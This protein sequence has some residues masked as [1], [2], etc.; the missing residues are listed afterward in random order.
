MEDSTSICIDQGARTTDTYGVVED[1][2]IKCFIGSAEANFP[3][4]RRSINV[5]AARL[6]DTLW[7]SAAEL[8]GR[9]LPRNRRAL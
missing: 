4:P 1:C 7:R 3:R 9:F 5:I 2:L 8:P 6:R